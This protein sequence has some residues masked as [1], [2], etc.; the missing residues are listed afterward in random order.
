MEYYSIDYYKELVSKYNILKNIINSYEFQ[1]LKKISFLGFLDRIFQFR[2]DLN[3]SRYDHSLGVAYLAMKFCEDNSINENE[4]L[5]FIIA[6]LLH[7][8]G[9]LPFSH[10]SEPVYKQ[11]HKKRTYKII[12]ST[13]ESYKSGIRTILERE[14][15][16]SKEII[17]ILKGNSKYMIFND[18]MFNNINLDTL[19][20]I[21]RCAYCFNLDVI[22]PIEILSKFEI[23]EGRI[24]I[25]KNN[26]KILDA[27]WLLKN[28][29]YRDFIYNEKN[30]KLE[31]MVKKL[32]ESY[33][34]F[35]EAK[36]TLF[37]N[38]NQLIDKIIKLNN[39]QINDILKKIQDGKVLDMLTVIEIPEKTSKNLIFDYMNSIN[40]KLKDKLPNFDIYDV[41]KIRN[42]YI[43]SDIEFYTESP[44][45]KW[46]ERRY[47]IKFHYQFIGAFTEEIK[48]Q[49]ITF[50]LPI[51]KI[52]E[53]FIENIEELIDKTFVGEKN[54][55]TGSHQG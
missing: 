36:K 21:N 11:D 8:L 45:V 51:V 14:N 33:F 12:N 25:N 37:F 35:E 5:L 49:T 19:D 2:N 27:F 32:L 31:A 38:D 16:P 55:I 48:D 46:Y 1:R 7:D 20:A 9:H 53:K 28:K 34:N 54:R 41:R 47:R 23:R 4:S 13:N 26:Y 42:F 44:L 52:N 10:V 17:Y 30:L 40:E 43:H 29:V 22:N 18:L 6:N 15:I 39:E 3:Y 50:K 24:Y